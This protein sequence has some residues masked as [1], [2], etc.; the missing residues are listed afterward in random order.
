[1]KAFLVIGMA[2]M[3]WAPLN[4]A[5]STSV[6]EISM[7]TSVDPAA[8]LPDPL[9]VEAIQGSAF[10]LERIQEIPNGADFDSEYFNGV[11]NWELDLATYYQFGCLRITG[12]PN[13]T[14]K[15]FGNP[16]LIDGFLQGATGLADLF[17]GTE[18]GGG[19][20]AQTVAG[21]VSSEAECISATLDVTD[22]ATGINNTGNP[23]ITGFTLSATGE[24]FVVWGLAIEDTSGVL[25]IGG[26][27]PSIGRWEDNALLT[28]G[29]VEFNFEYVE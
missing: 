17:P 20:Q 25:R 2:I 7:D 1:M 11:V 5:A 22:S 19:V 24:T 16:I 3:F 28:G 4:A 29:Q 6:G 12:E 26:Q 23:L 8:I 13:S 21:V 9:G 27:R 10:S 14:V 15:L 18:I